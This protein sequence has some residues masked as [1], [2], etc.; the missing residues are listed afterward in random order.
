MTRGGVG[1]FDAEDGL[2]AVFAT[3]EVE[4]DEA[5]HTVGVGEGDGLEAVGCRSGGKIL[6]RTDAGVEGA[7]G[8]TMEGDEQM[9]LFRPHPRGGG[10]KA[11]GRER[12]MDPRCLGARDTPLHRYS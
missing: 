4:A 5:A 1:E 9:P 6:G 7:G 10:R 12:A 8:M 3:G 11:E 2:D